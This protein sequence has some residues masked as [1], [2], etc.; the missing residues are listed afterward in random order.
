MPPSGMEKPNVTMKCHCPNLKVLK[1]WFY[2]GVRI[3]I[4]VSSLTN[5]V[6]FELYDNR[7][8]QNLPPLNQLPFPKSVTLQY[9]E[10]LE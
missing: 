5:L 1:L 9:M 3:P 8:L 7:R 10:A 4:W 2:M 6:H